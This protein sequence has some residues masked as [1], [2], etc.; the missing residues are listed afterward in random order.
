M[1]KV[2]DEQRKQ[3]GPVELH[4]VPESERWGMTF[5]SVHRPQR[6]QGKTYK[7]KPPIIEE[8]VYITINDMAMPDGSLRPIEVFINSKNMASFQWISLLTRLLSALFRQ[9]GPFPTFVFEEF[10][11]TFDP[12]GAY[13]IPGSNGRKANS[14]AHHIGMV[15]VDHC[16]EIGV[17]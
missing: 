2:G 13:I 9:P 7:I 17:L 5:E 1:T 16:K 6:L 4:P 12:H 15:I 11:N 10:G 8:A 3:E 14:I